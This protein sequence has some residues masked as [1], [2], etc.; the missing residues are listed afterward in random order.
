MV[1]T[2]LQVFAR[3]SWSLVRLM[4]TEQRIELRKRV[5]NIDPSEK[6]SFKDSVT[7]A[8]ELDL[9]LAQVK[10]NIFSTFVLYLF[11]YLLNIISY[12]KGHLHL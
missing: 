3:H 2:L 11:F 10:I 8:K 7:I 12:F 5:E 9:T 4:S 1:S 6:V